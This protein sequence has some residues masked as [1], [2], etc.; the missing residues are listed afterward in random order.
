MNSSEVMGLKSYM[1]PFV[2]KNPKFV[3]LAITKLKYH[4]FSL[5]LS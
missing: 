5:D 4:M 1:C 2:K 3:I